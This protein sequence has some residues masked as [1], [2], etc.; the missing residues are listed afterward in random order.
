VL[1]KSDDLEADGDDVGNDGNDDP[2]EWN[3]VTGVGSSLQPGMW[4]D[5]S[6]IP[7]H[8]LCRGVPD[9]SF[10]NPSGAGFVWI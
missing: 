10:Q 8:L 4:H 9:F 5:I 2:D 1:W 7:S 3:V 6:H